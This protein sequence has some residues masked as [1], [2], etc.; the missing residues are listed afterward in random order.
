MS[1]RSKILKNANP[2]QTPDEA[3]VEQQS[4][5]VVEK[6][7][8]TNWELFD[9]TVALCFRVAIVVGIIGALMYIGYY[10]DSSKHPPI[11]LNPNDVA[12]MQSNQGLKFAHSK[13]DPVFKY[14][15]MIELYSDV[16]QFGGSGSHFGSFKTQDSMPKIF[17][18]YRRSLGHENLEVTERQDDSNEW[19]MVGIDKKTTHQYS[20]RMMK[21]SDGMTQ[22]FFSKNIP[23]DEGEGGFGDGSLVADETGFPKPIGKHKTYQV[24]TS[25][26]SLKGTT[27][28]YLCTDS[29]SINYR[30]FQKELSGLGWSKN[31]VPVPRT[32]RIGGLNS[33]YQKGGDTVM[34]TVAPSDDPNWN[35]IVT[36]TF[37]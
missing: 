4:E 21:Q 22:V 12:Y 17:R 20:V 30:H 16:V 37:F 26:G 6:T 3:P 5:S 18:H 1:K 10:L 25:P 23:I 29:S 19:S 34:L 24:A 28:Y 36:M 35:S 31:P 27:R 33:L 9:Q 32:N 11:E 7:P 8:S 13:F 2:A 15:Q 14:P